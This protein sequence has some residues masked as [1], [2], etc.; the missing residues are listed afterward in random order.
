M[1]WARSLS[2]LLVSVSESFVTNNLEAL[3]STESISILTGG[4]N[5]GIFLSQSKS[6]L[7]FSKNT[8]VIDFL[9]VFWA[10]GIF[11]LVALLVLHDHVLWT[12]RSNAFVTERSEV[13]W[14]LFEDALFVLENISFLAVSVTSSE[15]EGKSFITSG[16][17]TLSVDWLVVLILTSLQDTGLFSSKFVSGFTGNSFTSFT[18]SNESRSTFDLVTFLVLVHGITGWAS[19]SN[20]FT[21][22]E[23]EVLGTELSDT[24]TVVRLESSWALLNTSRL[25]EFPSLL[26]GSELAFISILSESSWTSLQSTFSISESVSLGTDNLIAF[27]VSQI[28]SSGTSNSN[29]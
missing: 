29:A 4:L 6:F 5:T 2:A 9:E 26:T 16:S 28:E 13:F 20:A 10:L 19:L 17:L 1:F 12:G 27:S 23:V 7:A 18:L 25:F 24:F 11:R 8:S 3:I 21:V 15:S 22:F 14:A